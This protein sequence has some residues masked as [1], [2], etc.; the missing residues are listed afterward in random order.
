M[1]KNAICLWYDGEA[2]VAANFYASV[3]P[4]S[5]VDAVHRAPGPSIC[6]RRRFR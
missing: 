4:D 5:S 6:C 2:E 1:A 3:F